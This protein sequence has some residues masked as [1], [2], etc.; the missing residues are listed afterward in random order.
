MIGEPLFLQ[1]DYRACGLIG[2]RFFV[3][4]HEGA[5]HERKDLDSRKIGQLF[6]FGSFIWGF[7]AH[8][9]HQSQIPGFITHFQKSNRSS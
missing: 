1:G 2:I 7:G 4:G 6:C 5:S 3:G 9:R 8:R